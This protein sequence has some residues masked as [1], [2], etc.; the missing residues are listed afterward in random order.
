MMAMFL[1]VLVLLLFGNQSGTQT[2]TT[3]SR[4]AF[5]D[6]IVSLQFCS[7]ILWQSI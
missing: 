5:E 6:F 1:L 2:I 7:C 3:Y 4:L